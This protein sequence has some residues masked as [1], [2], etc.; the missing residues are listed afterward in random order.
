MAISS[1]A[2]VKIIESRLAAGNDTTLTAINQTI[3]ERG[4]SAQDA[5]DI[6]IQI[7]D[8]LLGKGV[9]QDKIVENIISAYKAAAYQLL[10]KA[11]IA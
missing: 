11:G 4:I 10:Q 8:I 5:L 9:A 1:S 3:S 6:A 2:V 7:G